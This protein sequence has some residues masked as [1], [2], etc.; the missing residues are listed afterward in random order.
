[1]KDICLLFLLS[2]FLT[3]EVQGKHHKGKDEFDWKTFIIGSSCTIETLTSDGMIDDKASEVCG[4]CY[5][6]MDGAKATGSAWDVM[7]NCSATFLP[8]IYTSCKDMLDRDQENW[9]GSM[10][11]M[12]GYVE[13]KDTDG[14]VQAAVKDW[15]KHHHHHKKDMKKKWEF[16]IGASCLAA[17]H[18]DGSVFDFENSEKC[19]ECFDEEEF[20]DCVEMFLPSMSDCTDVMYQGGEEEGMKCF[21]EHLEKMDEDGEARKIMEDYLKNKKQHGQSWTDWITYMF[22]TFWSYITSWF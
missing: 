6:K 19:G 3:A 10:E 18:L 17:S 13:E 4:E 16:I 7:K 12:Y 15:M 9:D 1:M 5:D 11:C 20:R 21:N 8:N 22:L 2:L 14:H